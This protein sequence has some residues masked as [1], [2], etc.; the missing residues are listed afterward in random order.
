MCGISTLGDGVRIIG[1]CGYILKG[2]SMGGMV[3][4]CIRRVGKFSAGAVVCGVVG[5]LK[6]SLNFCS[7]FF[8]STPNCVIVEAG[9]G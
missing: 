9:C 6:I 5:I 7:A 8:C 4:I 2:F 3:G 1:A